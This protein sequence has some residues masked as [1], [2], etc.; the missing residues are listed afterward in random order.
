MHG[1]MV[2]VLN[3]G[4]VLMLNK[5]VRPDDPNSGYYTLPG[6]KLEPFEKGIDIP[7]GR[8]ERAIREV[9]EETGIA[10][11]NTKLRGNILFDNS[12]RE[13][14]DWPNP[15]DY[16]VNVYSANAFTFQLKDGGEGVPLWVPKSDIKDLPK[17]LGDELIYGWLDNIF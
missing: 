14:P 16:N 13:F 6:G 2:Y 5:G 12:E 8:L 1:L 15:K 3:K 11:V 17:H 10:I 9:P 7:N 4:N